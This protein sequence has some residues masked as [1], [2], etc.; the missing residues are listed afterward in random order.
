[1]SE[2]SPAV[3]AFPKSHARRDS[4]LDAARQVFINKGF[5]LTTIQDI[6]TSC[7]MSPGN[8]YRYFTSKSDIVSGLVERDRAQMAERFA[9]LAAAP[10]QIESFEKLGRQHLKEECLTHAKLTL[11]IWAASARRPELR[12]LCMS[13]EE[14]VIA[15][16]KKFLGRISAENL[17]APGAD[18][19][20]ICHIIMTLAQAMFR[21]SALKP[22]HDIDRDLDVM[23]A[24]IGAAMAGHIKIPQHADKLV[25]AA[26]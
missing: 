17:L 3:E 22:D 11:E 5:E 26:E 10:D 19:D 8:L 20:V 14:A 23:F 7:G 21:D 9:E 2:L 13:M 15:D 16:L 12:Q 4:I 25:K 24:V 18:T 6:A 1:V